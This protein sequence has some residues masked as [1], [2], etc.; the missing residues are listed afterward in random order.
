MQVPASTPEKVRNQ[1]RVPRQDRPP[2][3]NGLGPPLWLY[4]NIAKFA[5]LQYIR[6]LQDVIFS[7]H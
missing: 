5:S 3:S 1:A 6:C 7:L 2:P 4:H